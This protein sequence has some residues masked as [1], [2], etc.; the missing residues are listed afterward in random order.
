MKKL[1]FVF[2]IATLLLASV[3]NFVASEALC[4]KDVDVI[5]VI[6]K[7]ASIPDSQFQIVKDES[8]N[9]LNLLNSSNQKIGLASFARRG[10]L[11]AGL[12]YNYLQIATTIMF[13]TKQGGGTNMGEGISEA[14]KEFLSNGRNVPKYIILTSD[15]L[16]NVMTN[17]TGDAIN[18]PTGPFSD[19]V[20]YALDEAQSAKSDGV[21][22]FTIGNNIPNASFQENF[23]KQIASDDEKYFASV[24]FSNLEEIYTQIGTEICTQEAELIISDDSDDEEILINESINFYAEYT[25][26]NTGATIDNATCQIAFDFGSGFGP[27][28]NMSYDST[29]EF[30]IYEDSFDENGT[31]E[32]QIICSA[33]GYETLTDVDEFT[34][35]KNNNPPHNDDGKTSY[36]DLYG[37]SLCQPQWVCGQWNECDNGVRTR[38]CEDQKFCGTN[39]LKP[40]ESTG[41]SLSVEGNPEKSFSWLWLIILVLIALILIVV[42]VMILLKR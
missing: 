41:C 15:G 3:G 9:F 12:S 35:G 32:Y 26:E 19:C 24:N 2:L 37:N 11:N 29:S 38:V 4:D 39:Y 22:I 30:F 36:Y 40:I 33:P 28:N 6:D 1:M 5:L 17:S 21:T 31:F 16:P 8:I 20:D 23:M 13:M 34:I 25:D 7:S 42:L 18:C 14:H 27:W 10:E